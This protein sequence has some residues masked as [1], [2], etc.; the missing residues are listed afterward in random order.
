MR[1]AAKHAGFAPLGA[2]RIVTMA[3]PSHDRAHAN[4]TD[5]Q[6]R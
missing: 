2:L 4:L 5:R 1:I 6:P 3:K